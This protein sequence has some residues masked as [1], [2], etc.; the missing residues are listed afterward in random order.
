MTLRQLEMLRAVA[1]RGSL[2]EA[3]AQLDLTQPAVSLQMK[4]LAAELG[5]PLY[6]SRGRRVEL[7]P[8]GEVLAE[9]AERILR[10]VSDGLAAARL[11]RR[12][13]AVVRVAASSTPGVGLLPAL[14]ARYR[15]QSPATLVR[16][17]VLNSAQVEAKV[18]SGEA[19]F[20]VVGGART[21]PGLAAEQWRDDELVLIVAPD[22][23]LAGRRRVR[24]SELE[25][26]TLL[27]REGGSA[28]RAAMASAFLRAR[29]PM[30]AVHVLG[31][32]EAIKAAVAEGLGIGI[33]SRFTIR[34][35]LASG[36]LLAAKIA[37]VEL[38]RPL[39][40]VRDPAQTPS[41]AVAGFLEF[42]RG[43]RS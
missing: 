25:G 17:E 42:V 26:E 34:H 29:V 41:D 9:F 16:L 37:G 36:R 28:T 6:R 1:A 2:T 30:P 13:A 10:L 38:V 8:A 22:H 14:I 20:G 7:T 27:V 21:A 4:S 33:V 18:A 3:A 5:R 40:I 43:A 15:E 31:D 11:G 24:S 23:A 35:E 19:D 12:D 39:L 32:N